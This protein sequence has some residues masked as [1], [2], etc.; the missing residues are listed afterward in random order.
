MKAIKDR[1]MGRKL[2]TSDVNDPLPAEAS[3][4]EE[5]KTDVTCVVCHDVFDEPVTLTCG[6]SFCRDCLSWWL[7]EHEV[8]NYGKCAKCNR[9][10]PSHHSSFQVNT[11]LRACVLAIFG[12]D[13]QARRDERLK[14]TKGENG[15][16]HEHGS[17]VLTPMED[18][19]WKKLPGNLAVRRSVVLDA[20]DQR[21]QWALAL[22]KTN[23][24]KVGDSV[25]VQLCSLHLE[26]DEAADGCI[27]IRVVEEDDESMI[28]REDDQA[29][30]AVAKLTDRSER[31]I[32][33]KDL[34]DGTV[35]FHIGPLALRNAAE[36][37]FYHTGVKTKLSIHLVG[38][39]GEPD[40]PAGHGV[41]GAAHRP[42]GGRSY[43]YEEEGAE[44][45]E[46]GRNEY[47][48]GFLVGDDD[49][50]A[51]ADDHDECCVCNEVGELMMCDGGDH[52]TG[53]GRGFHFGCV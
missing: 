7:T 19:P 41:R 51:E 32:E 40:F 16:A 39:V 36:L 6:H 53:C 1:I 9:Q 25:I 5:L 23:P 48:D 45:V 46:D 14:T 10:L 37:C 21:M 22:Y 47:D 18:E 42:G 27:P 35:E 44:I 50:E 12:D 11:G 24:V 13:V 33:S 34:S 8:V 30:S 3:T 2:E 43:F 52:V 15:G 29:V 31:S 17:R 49:E 26:E 20:D 28:E 38:E 4:L